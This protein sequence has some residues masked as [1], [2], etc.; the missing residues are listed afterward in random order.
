MRR[1]RGARTGSLVATALLLAIGVGSPFALAQPACPETITECGCRI[2]SPGQYTLG[3]PL[4]SSS[5]GEECIDVDSPGV[6][7]DLAG[8]SIA[9]P[10]ANP[11]PALTK[12][13]ADGINFERKASKA[14]LNGGGA[15]VSGFSQGVVI[16][17]YEDNA[18]DFSTTANEVG[19]VLF[20]TRDSRVS[21]FAA[22]SNG[23]DGIMIEFG[24]HNQLSGFAANSNGGGGVL[25]FDTAHNQL[26]GFTANSNADQGVSVAGVAMHNQLTGFTANSNAGDG[27]YLSDKADSNEISGFVT[28]SNDLS[29][30]DIMR[31]PVGRV[32]CVTLKGIPC[33]APSKRNLVEDGEA[34]DNRSCGIDVVNTDDEEIIG[35]TA[36]SNG[37]DDLFDS[38]PRCGADKWQRNI[39]DTANR[40]CIH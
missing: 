13:T 34:E 6:E 1:A 5:V 29:G 10:L 24:S 9:G 3:K 27:V 30:V 20:G 15:T 33:N 16:T 11:P 8:F 2:L 26:S 35:N 31:F 25:L 37:G 19:V 22:S 18:D 36:I 39:F 12:V 17:G 14:I 21:N 4:V 40:P 28:D 7:L 38:H 32:A 23:Q